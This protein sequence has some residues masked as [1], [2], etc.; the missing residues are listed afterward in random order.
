MSNR[1]TLRPYQAK[2]V[3]EITLAYTAGNRSVLAVAATGSGKTSCAA[4]IIEKTTEEGQRTLFLAHR[5]EL[6]DQCSARLDAQGIGHGIIKA[7]NKRVNNSL[8]QV[9][10]VQTLI[11]R[12]RPKEGSLLDHAYHAD[13]IIIDEA[14]RAG[15]DTYLE[16]LKAFPAARVLGLTATPIRSDGKGLSDLFQALVKVSS[17]SELTALGF[18]VP[19]TVYTTPLNPDFSKIKTKMG[20]YDKKAVAA[21]M[22]QEDLVGDIYA[23]WKRLA[24]DRQTIIFACSLQH[25]AHIQAVFQAAGESICY[26]D[27]E[28]PEEER[29]ERL[30]AYAAGKYRVVVNVGILTEGYDAPSTGCVVLARPTKSLGLYLQMAG[31]GLR[32]SPGKTD[33]IILDHGGNVFRHGLVE[34]DRDWDLSGERVKRRKRLTRCFACQCVHDKRACPACGNINVKPKEENPLANP[35][36]DSVAG[37]LQEVTAETLQLRRLHEVEFFR[38]ALDKQVALGHSFHYANAKFKEKF[39]R[40]P[41]KEI[42]IKTLWAKPYTGGKPIGFVFQGIE[43]LAEKP[44][45]VE[46]AANIEDDLPF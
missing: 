16:I 4:H 45:P 46:I 10:S 29:D 21:A 44:K 41:G 35:G 24:G 27:G 17:V 25:A 2:A 32:P 9:A 26:V 30:A 8:V 3:D 15:A 23:N 5:K 34:E 13:L 20:E 40:Y 38:Q 1:Q 12:V 11:N 7:G 33:M 42:G 6:I 36:V 14:H 19:A 39:G 22:D 31:R 28:T 37:D 18:L 43:V